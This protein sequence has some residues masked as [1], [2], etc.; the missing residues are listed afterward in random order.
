MQIVWDYEQYE[1][2]RLTIVLFVTVSL[3]EEVCL[4]GNIPGSY[5][6]VPGTSIRS[7]K[8]IDLQPK[9]KVLACNPMC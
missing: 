7:N 4:R 8:N 9:T 5:G 2:S 3:A 6:Y 1:R